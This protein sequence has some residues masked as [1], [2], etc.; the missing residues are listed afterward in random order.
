MTLPDHF[1]ESIQRVFGERG[2]EWLPRLPELVARCREKW[3]L[4]PGGICPQLSLNYL[5]LT[6]TEEGKPVALKV[7]VP[8][9][10]CFTEMEALRL[11][12][13]RGAVRLLASDAG[14]GALLLAR[15]HPGT[16][17]RDHGDNAEQTRIAASIMRALPV[18]VPA[19][20]GLPSFAQWTERAFRLT[21]AEWGPHGLM[22]RDL[23]DAAEQALAALDGDPVVLH[24]DLHHENIL[25]DEQ[26]GWVAI[27]PKGAVGPACLEVGRFLQNQLPTEG[28]E[29]VVGERIAIFSEELGY[30]PATVA[31][32]GL[33]DCVLSHCWS[34]EDE[35]LG[36]EWHQ[37]VALA[38]VLRD[39]AQRTVS[40]HASGVSATWPR[41]RG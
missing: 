30:A 38:R 4:L 13:G 36:P 31:A 9:P 35:A 10:E 14:L 15:L 2:R 40:G 8:H 29:P 6:T 39:R 5:E 27:D 20:H 25:L 17:L 7:G 23:L 32:A 21:R 19:S 24:G 41:R 33:V 1:V 16:M 34:L 11:Y 28:W 12:G 22:P 3:R 26:A 18:P 37:G